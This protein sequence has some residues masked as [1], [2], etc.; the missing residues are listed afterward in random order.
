MTE[1]NLLDQIVERAKGKAPKA[2]RELIEEAIKG[3]QHLLW[4]PNPGPQTAAFRSE[5][6]ET[7]YG[8]ELGGGKT[9]LIVGLSLTE[10]TMSLLLRRTNKEAEKL[11]NEYE[12]I[13]QTRKGWNGRGTWRLPGGRKIDIGGCEHEH[14]KHEHE[15]DHDHG[16]D[17]AHVAMI[18]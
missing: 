17:H 1:T 9:G 8:G 13:L 11:V 2:R 3:T 15:H 14:D 7:G 5:A 10:H 4:V 16:H 18:P 12:E 6:D